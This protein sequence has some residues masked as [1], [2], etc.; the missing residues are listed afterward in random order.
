MQGTYHEPA[1][2]WRNALSPQPFC[3]VRK[4]PRRDLYPGYGAEVSLASVS[5]SAVFE[6]MSGQVVRRSDAGG[7][8]RTDRIPR[9][10]V[11]PRKESS[12]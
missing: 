1:S 4:N 5:R 12:Q 8:S 3:L 11:I 9:V 6:M 2:G 7:T 10:I